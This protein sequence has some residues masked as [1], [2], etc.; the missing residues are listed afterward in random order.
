M[1]LCCTKKLINAYGLSVVENFTN[2]KTFSEWYA[3]LIYIEKKKCIL[4]TESKTLFSIILLDLKKSD[5]INIG[6]LFYKQLYRSLLQIGIKE[7]LIKS[8]V[9]KELKILYSTTQDKR[10]LGSMNDYAY[11]YKHIILAKGWIGYID[12]DGII[13]N[14][15]ETPMSLIGYNSANRLVRMVILNEN[16]A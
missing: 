10:I 11:Q 15:N 5:I 16:F 7:D 8:I 13:Q 2:N 6:E 4:F 1:I 3:N 9:P 12:I 14:I